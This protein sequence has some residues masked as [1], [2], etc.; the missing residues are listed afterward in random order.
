MG[1]LSHI[2]RNATVWWLIE[3]SP[4]LIETNQRK[5]E[6]I[7]IIIESNIGPIGCPFI[8]IEHFYRWFHQ[9]FQQRAIA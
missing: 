3:K 2:F 5:W 4:D 7:L 8:W 6:E 1:L 9:S